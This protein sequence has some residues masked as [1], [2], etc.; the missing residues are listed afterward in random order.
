[1]YDVSVVQDS[2]C[3]CCQSVNVANLLIITQFV[4]FSLGLYYQRLR[5]KRNSRNI[6]CRLSATPYST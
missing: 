5:V 4:I 2:G 1:M 6:P 3:V